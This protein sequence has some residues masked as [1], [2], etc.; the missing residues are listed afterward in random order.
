MKCI[1]IIP[2]LLVGGTQRAMCNLAL[3]LANRGREVSLIVIHRSDKTYG[4]LD[5]PRL[6]IGPLVE[7]GVEIVY[8]NR[9]NVIYSG[10]SVLRAVLAAKPD[11]VMSSLSYLNLYL[12]FIFL[13][14]PKRIAYIVRESNVLS[15]KH[16]HTFGSGLLRIVY[17][18][19]YK[20]VD[21]VVCQSQDMYE[22]LS[23]NFG[24]DKEKMIVINNG[25]DVERLNTLALEPLDYELNKSCI[26]VV[27]VGHL[28]NQKGH[29][30]L[31]K[32]LAAMKR[33]DVIVH[34]AG[35]G[36]LKQELEN[37]SEELGVRHQ[38]VF[39][40]FMSN[41]FP[42]IKACDLF[43]LASRFEGFP[44]A[45]VE[46]RTLGIPVLAS[47]CRGGIFEIL[48]TSDRSFQNDDSDDL[49]DK[50]ADFVRVYL[51][52]RKPKKVSTKEFSLQ[53]MSRKF[54]KY[55]SSITRGV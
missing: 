1:L 43:V 13:M 29:D 37:L 2:N 35:R 5:T 24:V 22:D 23:Q 21:H 38:V 34:I 51:S 32:A 46:A 17:S 7:A 18:L 9:Q 55:F 33:D 20:L 27:S 3:G 42:L 11:I 47:N 52:E 49:K 8:L 28:T 36:P 31:I 16:S 14:L 25:V 6:D 53:A 39:H 10:F 40:G 41:P 19:S 15:V 54:D 12:S 44:N 4:N 30:L 48:G 50:L 45:L 26:N